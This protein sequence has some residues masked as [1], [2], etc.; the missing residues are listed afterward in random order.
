MLFYELQKKCLGLG[1]EEAST[2]LHHSKSD[3]TLTKNDFYCP[4]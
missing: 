3:L 1:A 4:Y 2:I